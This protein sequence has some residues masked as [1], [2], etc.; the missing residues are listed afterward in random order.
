M[1]QQLIDISYFNSDQLFLPNE[2]KN[3][4]ILT[5]PVWFPL[6][7]HF[8]KETYSIE[9]IASSLHYYYINNSVCHI[10]FLSYTEAFSVNY[11]NDM[12]KL[13]KILHI[14]YGISL[15]TFVYLS[16]AHP[17]YD[18]VLLYKKLC[19]ENNF[20]EIK[21]V[22]VNSM[23]VLVNKS[24]DNTIYLMKNN[25]DFQKYFFNIFTGLPKI[26]D[27]KF[28]SLNGVPRLFRLIMTGQFINKKLLNS[29]FFTLW[30]DPNIPFDSEGVKQFPNLF[31]DSLESLLEQ[32]ENFPMKLHQT[33]V[34]TFDKKDIYYFNN[35][36]F[37]VVAET[38]FCKNIG[39]PDDIFYECF[40]F[41]EKLFR[42]IKLMH[43]FVL[44]ARPQSLRVLKDY[45]Y[46]TFHPFINESYD[47]IEDDESRMVAIIEEVNRLCNLSEMQLFDLR[48]KVKEIT[49]HNYYHLTAM[50]K[51]AKFVHYTP[52][53]L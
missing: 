8:S 17:V 15:S 2:F 22:L 4:N 29:G 48:K 51:Q 23:E 26:K 33:P 14:K 41:S 16:G 46:K 1:L 31:N 52:E 50:Q 49:K 12:Q 38:V 11:I 30:Y 45:G 44:L 53:T 25:L 7:I 20:F 40:D 3:K 10:I 6:K 24:Y 32:K 43:P 42:A 19:S 34:D 9:E 47:C 27:K 21:L 37:S 36:Y 5:L 39:L 28:I 13:I 18:N 35:S